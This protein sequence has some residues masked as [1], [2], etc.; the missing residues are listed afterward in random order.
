MAVTPLQLTEQDAKKQQQRR[1]LIFDPLL[2]L[3][4][5][6]LLGC[7][8]L[9]MKGAKPGEVV[10]QAAYGAIGLV[11]CVLVSRID[12]TRW[13]EYRYFFYGLLIVSNIVVYA[14]PST[15]GASRWI[16]L[17]FFN[18]QPSEFG[19]LLLILALAAFVVDRSRK[20]SSLRLTGR[21]LIAAI[22]PAVIVIGQPDLG[23][24]LVYM[25]ICA[26]MLYFGG[27]SW[28]QLLALAVIAILGIGVTLGAG[29]A[30]GVHLLKPYQS[31]RLTTFLDPPKVCGT[32]DQ[33]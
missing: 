18:I 7:S 27:T 22:V 33:T 4:A 3:A 8:L 20:E 28:K 12:Y 14:M 23:T 15:L 10:N 19:K 1:P 5:I 30:V 16:P 24:G 11:A 29:P 25:T 13:R 32:Q 2:M 17:P 21:I 9:T 31:Q 6:G 26:A